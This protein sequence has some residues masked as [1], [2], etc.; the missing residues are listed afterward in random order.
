MS[1]E[2][3]IEI[4][5]GFG[6][7]TVLRFREEGHDSIGRTTTDL[8]V[9]FEEATHECYR[10]NGNDLVYTHKVSLLDALKS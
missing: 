10:R 5:P 8:V 1:Q 7:Q 3:K 9:K 2:K 4:K 6:K